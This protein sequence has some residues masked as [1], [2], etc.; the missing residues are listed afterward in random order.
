MVE[1][2]D[3]NQCFGNFLFPNIFKLF[4]IAIQPGRLL[5][6][7]LAL[8]LIFITGWIMDF[9][10]TVIV[11]GRVS[12]RELR[13]SVLTGSVTW[14]T[15]LHCFVYSPDR[16]NR[17][18]GTD[19]FIRTYKG[20]TIPE[21]LGVFKVFSN[22]CVANF[23]A[24]VVSLLQL[25]LDLF[26]AAINNCV[27]SFIW[28]LK[29]HSIYGS[30]FL[31]ISLLVLSIAGGAICR[32]AALQLSKDEKHGSIPCL[33]Y[34]LK[35][36]LPLFFA[37][38]APLILVAS[39]GFVIVSVIGLITS[40][41][42][43]GELILV[44]V[45]GVVLIAGFIM[46]GTVI[47]ACAGINLMFGA[48]AYDNS[49]TFDAWGRSF[50]Y[51]YWRPWRLG[52]YT[53][54][55]AVYGSI[56]YLFVRFF[57]FVLLSISRWFLQLGVL[58]HSS[59]APQFNKLAVIWPSPDFFNLL[60]NGLDF[61]K[62]LTETIAAGVIYFVILVISGMVIAFAVSFYFSA[63]SVIY[64]LLRNKVDNIAIG[65]VFIETEQMIQPDNAG[66]SEQPA[67]VTNQE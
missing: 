45:F 24:A 65:D 22:F 53:L 25:K 10:K 55:A 41:P 18:D 37:P 56:C 31:L 58:T 51:V 29:Y 62:S 47:F 40:I 54:L 60:G 19:I 15:E 2:K 8:C 12:T 44:L 27:L 28:M 35:R 52:F 17:V 21:R 34:A 67:Q 6:A 16:T 43:A 61:S 14:P 26:I 33:K 63:G 50:N 59:K 49:D 9:S 23:N 5:T 3:I 46:A 32:G 36:F 4:R 13:S 30:I 42:W 48:I 11:S 66:Q 38:T 20:R 57:A 1:Q 7:F 39:L 64:C